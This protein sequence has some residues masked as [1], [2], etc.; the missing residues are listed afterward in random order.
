MAENFDE[1]YMDVLQIIEF[2]I[3]QVYRAQPELSD[4]NV[5]KALG[6][7]VRVYQSQVTGRAAPKLRLREIEQDVFNAVKGM[8]DWRLG[9][10]ELER[11]D[12]VPDDA[13]A[14]DATDSADEAAAMLAGPDAKTP[15]E[16][17][18]CL[19]RIR[20]SVGIWTRKGGRQ[21]YLTYIAQFIM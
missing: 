5:E 17:V 20:K 14:D 10:T 2:A 12:D 8:C 21:G 9:N 15:E 7:L 6:A 16:I 18:A 1:Q 11:P 13:V 4:Y 3:M 19:K